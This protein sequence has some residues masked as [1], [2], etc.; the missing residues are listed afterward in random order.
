[1][2]VRIILAKGEE[3]SM[4]NGGSDCCGTCSFNRVNKGKIQYPSPDVGYSFCEIREFKIEDPFWTY[5]NN[6]PRRNPLLVQTPR[7]PVWAPVP[8][9][10]ASKPLS[11]MQIPP[12][13]FPPQGDAMYVRIPYYQN[14]RP[15]ADG[16]EVCIVCGKSHGAT[17][18]V[19]LSEEDKKFFCSVAHYFEWWLESAPEAAP[20]R[21]KPRR[22]EDTIKAE[23]EAIRSSLSDAGNALRTTGNRRQITRLLAN[24]EDLFVEL[25]YGR[26]DL[27]H[28]ALNLDD[29]KIRGK[30]LQYR[31][32]LQLDLSSAGDLLQQEQLDVE[33]VLACLSDIQ[34]TVRRFLAGEPPPSGE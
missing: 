27:V 22:D 7:G 2:E 26:V 18:S 24:L 12:E 20:Y 14:A 9:D 21:D 4:P 29:P 32:R 3:D 16:A 11:G 10:L 17:I 5:C 30:P 1:L 13:L 15:D 19:T 25:G 6:H 34:D 28:A 33:A 23:L 8:Y 31:T